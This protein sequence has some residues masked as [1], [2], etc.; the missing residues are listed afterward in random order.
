MALSKRP[1]KGTRDFFPEL[2][3]GQDF[4]FTKMSQTA[5]LFG[6]EPYDGPLLEE[7]DLYRAKSGEELINDQIY[8]FIRSTSQQFCDLCGEVIVV[9]NIGSNINGLGCSRNC[10][11]KPNEKFLTIDQEINRSARCTAP[12]NVVNLC[13]PVVEVHARPD[14]EFTYRF[15]FECGQPVR[16]YCFDCS[17]LRDEK[18]SLHR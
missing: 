3:R 12:R 13:F 6:Y 9:E 8:S 18:Q 15:G 17:I 2:K 4:I 1:Y 16:R 14:M 10:I 5:H 7:V 11:D